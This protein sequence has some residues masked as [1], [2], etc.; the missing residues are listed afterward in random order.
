MNKKILVTGAS[1]HLGGMLLK[2]LGRIGYSNVVGTDLKKKNIKK[3]QRFILGN[4]K[5]F[6]TIIKMTKGI[7]A[8]VHFGAIPIED[9]QQNILHNNIWTSCGK[10]VACYAPSGEQIGYIKI[11]ELVSNVDFGGPTGSILFITSSTSFYMANLNVKG[12]KFK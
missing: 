5:N 11:P 4:L 8:I 6:K 12:A 9:T 3:N 7:H 2:A 1:G 10:G